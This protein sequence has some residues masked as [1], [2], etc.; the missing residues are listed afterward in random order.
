MTLAQTPKSFIEPQAAHFLSM[1]PGAQQ[2]DVLY[3][4]KTVKIF[5]TPEESWYGQPKY[6]V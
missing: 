6:C 1:G 4:V 3:N 5:Y 2:Y